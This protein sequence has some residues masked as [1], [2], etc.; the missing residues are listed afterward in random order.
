VA[1]EHQLTWTDPAWLRQATSWI[2]SHATVSGAIAQPHVRW[3]STV[4][5]V[6]TPEGLLWFKAAAPVHAFEPGLVE[7]LGRVA[8]GS[9]PE[10]VAL[11]R[12]RGWMLMRDAGERL[13]EQ[14]HA[15]E[16]LSRWAE[17][18]PRYAELQLAVVPC[19]D[20]LFAVGVPDQ[21]LAVL[22]ELLER[23][24][25]DQELL[26]S[27]PDTLSP[28]EYERVL[29]RVPAFV[30]MRDE[31]AAF[32]IPETI[33]HDDLHDANVFVRD[34]RYVFF[35]WGDSSVAHPFQT[36]VVTL[37]YLAW[38]FELEP[39]APELE[40]ARDA[41][42]EPWTQFGTHR[43]LR[44]AF[45]LAYQ[46]GTVSRALAHHRFL[47][48]REPELRGDEAVAVANGLRLFLAG[49]PIGTWS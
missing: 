5:A 44:R 45:D 33:Q 15:R 19:R 18:L 28:E 3:W 43:D 4:L 23:L 26:V 29:E 35:D 22:P 34:G 40:R 9:V 17:V 41:Y 36:L 7:L 47:T 39:R 24:L 31:L 10:L 27:G 13:R 8:P 37:R 1:A 11:D 30:A 21:T 12:D 20:D 46:V 6:P 16:D 48:A 49:G 38:R 2:R 25:A 42:L 14:M 32:G